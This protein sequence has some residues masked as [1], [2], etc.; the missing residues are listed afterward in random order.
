[1]N[2]V[3]ADVTLISHAL[4]VAFVIGGQAAILIG[5]S[6]GWGW[7]RTLVFRGA[8]A[9]AI[10]VVVVKAW[11]EIPCVLT[12]LENTLRERAGAAPYQQTFIGYWLGRLVYY[13]APP[14]VFILA[15]SLFALLALATWVAYP[16]TR[17]PR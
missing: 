11:L 17:S 8:H 1:V 6:S 16:P 7:T 9:A 14:W 13:S 5:W 3:L 15:Y 10:G 4:F 2:A 12:E